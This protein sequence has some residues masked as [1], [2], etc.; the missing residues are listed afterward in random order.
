MKIKTIKLKPSASL[1]SWQEVLENFRLA[2][3]LCQK[4]LWLVMDRQTKEM[5]I[6]CY[7]F[8]REVFRL[9]KKSGCLFLALYLKQCQFS[10]KTYYSGS[11]DRTLS[12]PVPVSLTRT[13]LPRIIPSFHRS[14]IRVGD[15]RADEI[16][17]VYLSLFSLSL[18]AVSASRVVYLILLGI[19]LKI[20]RCFFYGGGLH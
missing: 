12:L 14:L 2:R 8:L 13:G 7:L 10:L 17:R 1:L 5:C 6:A 19:L 18:C 11:F 3:G 9:K 15:E 4:V 16:V 20:Y